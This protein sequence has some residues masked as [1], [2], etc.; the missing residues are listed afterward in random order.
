MRPRELKRCLRS[1]LPQVPGALRTQ[2]RQG[3]WATLSPGA[4]LQV[5][6]GAQSDMSRVTCAPKAVELDH[7][8]STGCSC[9]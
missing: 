2:G 5:W 4:N 9:S 7:R 6:R 1:C 3:G 8:S